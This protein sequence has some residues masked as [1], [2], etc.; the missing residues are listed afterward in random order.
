MTITDL[1]QDI[2]SCGYTGHIRC[3]KKDEIIRAIVLHGNLRLLPMLLQIREGLSLYGLSDFMAKY[4]DVCKPLFVP[5]IEMK[6]D[7]DFILSIC[8]ADFSETG[9]NKR[10][11]EQTIMNHLQDFLQELEQDPEMHHPVCPS[12][13]PHAFL[14]WVTGQGHVPVLQAE[15]RHFKVNIKFN[16]DCQQEYGAHSICYPLVA[17][18]T[19]TITLPV[20]HMAAYDNFKV[21]LLEAF[22]QGQ[23]FLRV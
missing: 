14:Q 19:S 11:V 20:Q 15:K 2:L 12:L 7:A 17:A 8:K 6:A 21:V 22:L 9:S 10:Q 18:C 4:P 16:H 13:S 3:E 23:E 5:G 1:T